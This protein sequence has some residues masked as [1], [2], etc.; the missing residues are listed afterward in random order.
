MWLFR[1]LFAVAA[2]VALV[3]F[4]FFAIGIADGS[5]SSFN[6]TMWLAL[7][8]GVSAVLAV[9]MALNARGHRVAACAVL[10]IL[11]VPGLLA[12]LF[13]LS[14]IVMQPRWN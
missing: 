8:G 14:L 7:L 1:I 10:S 5:V 2:A 6:M 13:V 11:A 3:A 12:G 9:G 4:C